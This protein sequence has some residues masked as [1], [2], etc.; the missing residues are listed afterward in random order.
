MIIWD[1]L[2]PLLISMGHRKLLKTDCQK[3]QRQTVPEGAAGRRK[4][5]T[6]GQEFMATP[7]SALEMLSWDEYHV[8]FQQFWV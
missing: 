8:L 3:Y 5:Q 4:D 1:I 6:V 2:W 7:T